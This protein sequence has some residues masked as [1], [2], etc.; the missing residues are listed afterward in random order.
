M[1]GDDALPAAIPKRARTAVKRPDPIETKNRMKGK[2]NNI[3]KKPVRSPPKG[4][5]EKEQEVA[6]ALFDLANL[7]GQEVDVDD[8][9]HMNDRKGYRGKDAKGSK[10]KGK[11]DGG[12]G[13]GGGK[14]ATAAER[15]G[16]GSHVR[17]I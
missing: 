4:T 12:K 10:G 11:G 5:S 7:C 2:M 8:D 3:N 9:K 6:E 14:G 16:K 17:S 13:K 15:R 1:S